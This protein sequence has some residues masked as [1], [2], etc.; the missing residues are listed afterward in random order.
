MLYRSPGVLSLPSAIDAIPANLFNNKIHEQAIIV[1][2]ICRPLERGAEESS[3]EEDHEDHANFSQKFEK[4]CSVALECVHALFSRRPLFTDTL[5]RHQTFAVSV[6]RSHE[7]KQIHAKIRNIILSSAGDDYD[8][9]DISMRNYAIDVDPAP[10]ELVI[11]V[12]T[13]SYPHELS[14]YSEIKGSYIS[15]MIDVLPYRTKNILRVSLQ[16]LTLRSFQSCTNQ[17]SCFQ[18]ARHL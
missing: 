1:S 11:V 7:R 2:A 6:Q 13:S 14:H 5:C 3:E 17:G 9:E 4:R 18:T 8:V 15:S 16:E 10:L 12:S